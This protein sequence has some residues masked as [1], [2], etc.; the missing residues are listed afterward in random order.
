MEDIIQKEEVLEELEEELRRLESGQGREIEVRE[1]VGTE[2]L[3][4]RLEDS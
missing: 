4:Q 2:E 1:I 3:K